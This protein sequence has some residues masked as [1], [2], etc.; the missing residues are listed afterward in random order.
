M[1]NNQ[2]K[3]LMRRYRL[4][5]SFMFL[6]FWLVLC[7]EN[8]LTRAS[9]HVSLTETNLALATARQT[10][11]STAATS[12]TFSLKNQ[13]ST[14]S[15]A[16][17][18]WDPLCA[19]RKQFLFT[20]RD[21]D[22]SVRLCFPRGENRYL[23]LWQQLKSFYQLLDT[24]RPYQDGDVHIYPYFLV[25]ND[26]TRF[27]LIGYIKEKRKSS[28]IST[29]Y[30]VSPTDSN[31]ALLLRDHAVS[32]RHFGLYRLCS[33]RLAEPSGFSFAVTNLEAL[34]TRSGSKGATHLYCQTTGTGELYLFDHPHL[35]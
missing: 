11:L 29:F 12:E 23:I 2:R 15:S 3:M 17:K 31:N 20:C 34:S 10:P 16:P 4:N 8:A 28:G 7:L 13:G 22:K 1:A 14:P 6:I 21:T 32:D 27:H 24:L 5:P 25:T 30:Q 18:P 19:S 9:T 33:G 26:T 35:K